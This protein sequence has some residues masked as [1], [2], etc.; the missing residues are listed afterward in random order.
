MT[1]LTTWLLAQIAAE[2]ERA[3]AERERRDEWYR[4]YGGRAG[5]AVT[6]WDIAND[7]A[8]TLRRC[9]AYRAIMDAHTT[10]FD[11]AAEIIE[12][13]GE[14]WEHLTDDTTVL[15]RCQHRHN[16]ATLRA[17]ATIYADA[18]GYDPSWRLA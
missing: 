5:I 6:E 12:G 3:R 4:E 8:A 1:N 17:I 13:S 18:D 7:P 14:E 11:A 9:A 16:R 10:P 2:E 15:T